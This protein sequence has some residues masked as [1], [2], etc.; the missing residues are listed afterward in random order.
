LFFYLT[1]FSLA[2]TVN[3]ELR[4]SS[5]CSDDSD[6]HHR[7]TNAKEDFSSGEHVPNSWT[8]EEKSPINSPLN[9]PLRLHEW[10]PPATAAAFVLRRSSRLLSQTAPS[11]CA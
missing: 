1:G 11:E 10:I 7:S 8:T 6:A 9:S 5:H 3:F 4:D 2:N